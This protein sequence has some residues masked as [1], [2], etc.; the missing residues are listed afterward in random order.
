MLA[1]AAQQ[2]RREIRSQQATTGSRS[3]R[4]RTY[5]FADDRVTDHRLGSSRFGLG[6][7]LGGNML[8]EFIDELVE[9]ERAAR[10]SKFLDDCTTV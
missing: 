1:D 5:N 8:D 10:L 4:I 7:M 6:R 2:E 9:R 3:E